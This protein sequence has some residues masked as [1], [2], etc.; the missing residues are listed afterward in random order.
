[1]SEF[2]TP[3]VE[4]SYIVPLALNMAAFDPAQDQQF[5][6]R[7]EQIEQRFNLLLH[8]VRASDKVALLCAQQGMGKSTLLM[9][10]QQAMGDD[11]RLCL[12]NG[13]TLLEPTALTLHCLRELDVAEQEIQSSTDYNGLLKQRCQQL[14]RLN[15]KALVLIDDIDALSQQSI[16]MI[17]EWLSWRENEQFSGSS[18]V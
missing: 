8:L 2:V 16:S 17:M 6:F 1:M 7:G 9:Q 14:Q 4:P 18:P 11:V 10:L 5:F 13:R 12:I 15:V 3:S